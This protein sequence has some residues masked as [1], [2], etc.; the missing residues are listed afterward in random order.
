MRTETLTLN[1]RAYR[2][3][4]RAELNTVA[5]RNLDRVNGLGLILGLHAIGVGLADGWR[6]LMPREVFDDLVDHEKRFGRAS[7]IAEDDRCASGVELWRDNSWPFCRECLLP[8]TTMLQGD[9]GGR[10]CWVNR[11]EDGAELCECCALAE[12]YAGD[13]KQMISHVL[14]CDMGDD[15]RLVR[16]E[17]RRGRDRDGII[18]RLQRS[19][20]RSPGL[21]ELIRLH[22][23]SLSD[24][25]EVIARMLKDLVN[26]VMKSQRDKNSMV[27]N[28]LTSGT[29][30]S[31]YA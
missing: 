9:A 30:E 4:L 17:L 3:D 22:R 2:N 20:W 27:S 1:P 26:E 31:V 21:R 23:V 10:G 8:F 5:N 6:C 13:R 24:C 14:R 25:A 11:I 29:R 18:E 28:R 12:N 19:Y 15:S 16:V 7:G